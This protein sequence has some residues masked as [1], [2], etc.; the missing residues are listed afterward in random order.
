MAKTGLAA[1]NDGNGWHERGSMMR[2]CDS[3]V[4]PETI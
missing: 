4:I 2:A 3:L 1:A